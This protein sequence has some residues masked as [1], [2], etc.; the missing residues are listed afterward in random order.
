MKSKWWMVGI[1]VAFIASIG[2]GR[3]SIAEEGET[4]TAA[5]ATPPGSESAA[6]AAAPA[7]S[8]ASGQVPAPSP[9]TPVATAPASFPETV[10]ID[11]D[12]PPGAQTEGTWVWDTSTVAS[13]AKSHGHASA[14]GLQSH[15][16]TA[17]PQ[18]LPTGSMLTQQ[19]WLDPND[20]PKGIMLRL[21][22]A[23]GDQVGVYWEGEQEVFNPGEQEEVWYYGLLPELGKWTSLEVLT[24]DLGIEEESVTGVSFVTFDGR[25]L[26][27]KTTLAPAPPATELESF[28]E[29]PETQAAPAAKPRGLEQQ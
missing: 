13:G 10:W 27:D 11:D 1:A 22:L 17:Q 2:V 16:Y 3:I 7:P 20:P 21:K 12:L 15:G 28:P 18:T 24:E 25:A 9:A 6:P 26:W 8:T 14:K 19:V 29:I 5:A 23:S 4:K